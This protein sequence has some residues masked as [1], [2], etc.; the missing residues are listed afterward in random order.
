M[1]FH[2]L[3]KVLARGVSQNVNFFITSVDDIISYMWTCIEARKN[4]IKQQGSK[5]D[6]TQLQVTYLG[7]HAFETV[8]KRK[9]TRYAKL[10]EVVQ[11]KLKKMNEEYQADYNPKIHDSGTWQ[12]K[13][14]EEW[15]ELQ[16][17]TSRYLHDELFKNIF[18]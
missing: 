5:C 3:V 18:Y 12:Y 14:N 9:Q 8:L 6:L 10:L 16:A 15:K 1:K 11:G 7:I 4:I 13:L 2:C 17:A